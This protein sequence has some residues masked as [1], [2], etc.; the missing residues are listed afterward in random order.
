MFSEETT[1]CLLNEPIYEAER[2]E[3]SSQP[4]SLFPSHA[5]GRVSTSHNTSAAEQFIHN[6]AAH[7]GSATLATPINPTAVRGNQSA[8]QDGMED[9]P[10]FHLNP[11]I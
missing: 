7:A 4:A 11:V 5:M 10:L 8:S 1:N 3:L 9:D 6:G 2:G